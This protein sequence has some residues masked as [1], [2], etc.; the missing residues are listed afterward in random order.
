VLTY[1]LLK[2]KSEGIKYFALSD[3][4]NKKKEGYYNALEKTNICDPKSPSMNFNKDL[5]L[6]VSYFIDSYL[7]QMEDVKDVTNRILQLNIRIQHL[8]SYTQ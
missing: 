1:Y 7:I 5:S 4:Y 3:Y 8:S 2:K 6:W